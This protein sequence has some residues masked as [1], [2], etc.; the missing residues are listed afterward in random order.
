MHC[1]KTSATALRQIRTASVSRFSFRLLYFLFP[2][3]FPLSGFP[4]IPGSSLPGD[5]SFSFR[6]FNYVVR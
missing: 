4:G 2:R 5:Q 1:E 6:F 3:R